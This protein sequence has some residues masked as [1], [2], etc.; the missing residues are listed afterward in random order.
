M[1]IVDG[2]LYINEIKQLIQLYLQELNRDLNFQNIDHELQDLHHKYSFPHGRLLA[3]IV[4]NKVVGC[5]AYTQLNQKQ[6]EMK[7][8]YVLPQYRHKGIAQALI[9]TSYISLLKMIIKK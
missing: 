2:D 9:K 4:D 1:E 6:C 5:I 7:R 8:L 3:A